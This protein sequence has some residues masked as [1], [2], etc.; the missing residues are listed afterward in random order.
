[1]GL[2]CTDLVVLEVRVQV[3]APT[4]LQHGGKRVDVDLEDVQQADDAR[5]AQR[6]VDVVLAHRVAHVGRLLGL[7]PGAVQL[8]DL[9]RH[10]THPLQVI[11]L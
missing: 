4:Q 3:A 1:M 5:V 11:C 9:H 10:L 2:P 7:V 8:V 6:L